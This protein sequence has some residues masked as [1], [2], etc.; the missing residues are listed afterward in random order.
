MQNVTILG[1]NGAEAAVDELQAGA[2]VILNPPP[3]LLSGSAVQI[4]GAQA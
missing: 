3:G 2:Q 1:Q 4:V